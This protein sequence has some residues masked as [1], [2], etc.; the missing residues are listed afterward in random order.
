M[1]AND[2]S[3]PVDKNADKSAELHA[4]RLHARSTPP[5]MRAAAAEQRVS[6]SPSFLPPHPPAPAPRATGDASPPLGAAMSR[7]HG[8]MPLTSSNVAS[9]ASMTPQLPE[10]PG[11]RSEGSSAADVL[12]RHRQLAASLPL[13]KTTGEPPQDSPLSMWSPTHVEP[14]SSLKARDSPRSRSPR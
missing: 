12:A 6:P 2:A 10:R 11:R 9:L 14:L 7:A 8:V 3:L 4:S 5:K 1:E 13:R